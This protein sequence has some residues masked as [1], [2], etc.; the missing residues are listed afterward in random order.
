MQ[1]RGFTEGGFSVALENKDENMEEKE[2][3]QRR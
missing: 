3:K 2:E 1:H